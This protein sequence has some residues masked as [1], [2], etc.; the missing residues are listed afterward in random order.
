MAYI[1]PSVQTTGTLITAAIWNADIVANEIA[2]NAGAIALTSQAIGDL[3]IATSASQLGRVADVATGQVLVS[4][5]VATA[6]AYSA[7]PSIT[8][9]TYTTSLKSTTALATPGAL[10]ATQATA[11]ASTVS[12]AAIMGFGTTN[13]VSLMNRAGTVVLGVGPNTTAVNIPGTLAVTGAV[14]GGTYNSQTISSAANLTGTL[15]VGGLLTVSGFGTNR[16]DVNATDSG[17]HAAVFGNAYSSTTTIGR[18]QIIGGSGSLF[19][20]QFAQGYTT[21]STA[22]AASSRIYG[23]GSGGVS[24]V[25]DNASGAIRFYSGGTTEHMSLSSAGLLTVSGFGTHTFTAGGNAAYNLFIKNTTSGT[26]AYAA[27]AAQNS[28]ADGMYLYAFS[29]GYTTSG[30][31]MANAGVLQTDATA[32]MNI[33]A[34]HASGPIRFYSGGT[35]LRW[36]IGTTGSLVAGTVGSGNYFSSFGQDGTIILGGSG[37]ALDTRMSFWNSN[38]SV[39]SIQTSGAATLYNTTSDARLKR[40]RGV[41]KSTDILA[42]TIIHDFEWIADG[43]TGRGVFAQEAFTVVPFAISRGTDD[44]LSADGLP[45][46]PWGVDYSKF[47]P[48]LIVGWQQH[49]ATIQSLTA[50]IAALEKGGA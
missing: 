7:S 25:A 38:G 46:R 18:V 36:T 44:T 43:T 27:L 39:G 31:Y 22:I 40:D 30:P 10:S 8:A 42:R 47:V 49:D 5:G 33:A 32:G 29:A 13:D 3:V 45:R 48:D 11:F 4:G 20:D 50:R 21:S 2:I 35:T 34:T 16:F 24:I 26:G 37:S 28:A 12:G 17:I 41:V 1:A 9:L 6:P 15:A 19:L 23:S 14:T